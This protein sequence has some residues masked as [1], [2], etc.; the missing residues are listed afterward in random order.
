MKTHAAN[1]AGELAHPERAKVTWTLNST[2]VCD[3]FPVALRNPIRYVNSVAAAETCALQNVKQEGS[4]LGG[5]R[6]VYVTTR[7]IEA[8][9][10]MVVNY[11]HK[12]FRD[13]NIT[14]ECNMPQLSIMAARGD[15]EGAQQLLRVGAA[16]AAGA[17]G[18]DEGET[19]LPSSVSVDA[20]AHGWTA[21]MEACNRGHIHVT[22][23]LL[24]HGANVDATDKDGFTPLYLATQVR[25]GS[26]A[27]VGRSGGLGCVCVCVCA[28][29]CVC[30]P[31]V[32]EH[33]TN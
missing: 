22:R 28:C 15:A 9:E 32:H 27:V 23:V 5:G 3:G 10:E 19:V 33:I 25:S 29:A 26:R 16:E 4:M 20:R 13:T 31:R 21:L 8:G 1:R 17:G 6:V 7:A 30:V 24:H 11:G 14:Y 2:H 18:G 12:F